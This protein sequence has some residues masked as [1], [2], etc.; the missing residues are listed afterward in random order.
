M[1]FRVA[2]GAPEGRISA[3]RQWWN[4]PISADLAHRLSL[5]E[6]HFCNAF[7]DNARLML[8]RCFQMMGLA[9]P[10]VEALSQSNSIASVRIMYSLLNHR[11]S[12][13][14]SHLQYEFLSELGFSV[15][16]FELNSV[17][18][19]MQSLITEA[20]IALFRDLKPLR[21]LLVTPKCCTPT[22]FPRRG[23]GVMDTMGA[24]EL[25]TQ[26]AHAWL[27]ANGAPSSSSQAS[28]TSVGNPRGTRR[29]FVGAKQPAP[30]TV[31]ECQ[32]IRLP[33]CTPKLASPAT[34]QPTLKF[35]GK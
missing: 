6:R 23:P 11:H 16:R 24:P 15:I 31:L 13:G 4:G 2:S 33:S 34:P 3:Q 5:C 21:R 25:P 32:L 35:A 28:L 14:I 29:K 17:S 19:S 18:G 1:A 12:L 26:V 20:L 10:V 9:E 7:P 27:K 22:T 8:L 30:P